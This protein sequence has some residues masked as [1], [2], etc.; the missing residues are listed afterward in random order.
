MDKVKFTHTRK[1]YA[2]GG[3]KYRNIIRKE[4]AIER[5]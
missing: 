3:T 1:I 5:G 2:G 4:D